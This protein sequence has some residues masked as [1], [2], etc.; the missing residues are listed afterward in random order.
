MGMI[1]TFTRIRAADV[2]AIRG[3][4]ADPWEYRGERLDVDKAWHGMHFLLTGDA[5]SAGTT[6]LGLAVLGG[7]PVGDDVGTGQPVLLTTDQV[8]LVADAI[9]GVS[10]TD[11]RRRFDPSCMDEVYPAIWDE[12]DLSFDYVWSNFELVCSFYAAASRAGDGMLFTIA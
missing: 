9:G 8:R 2:D 6:P 11:L 10:A 3:G 7:T 5:W 4:R 12:G 1:G